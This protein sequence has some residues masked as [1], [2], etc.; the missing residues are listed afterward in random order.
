MSRSGFPRLAVRPIALLLL[1]VVV[2]TVSAA[3]RAEPQVLA[4]IKPLG[5]IA[6]EVVGQ[7]GEVGTLLHGSASPHDYAMRVSDIRRLRAADVVLWVGP[8]M[9][10]FLARP[11]ANLPPERILEAQELQGIHWPIGGDAGI[12]HGDHFHERDPH[13]WLDPRNGA[14]IARALAARL[15]EL[16]PSGADRY[17]ANA[18]RLAERLY[19]LDKDLQQR[20]QPV[21]GRGFAVYHEGYT[22]FIKRYELTQLGYV[23]FGPEQRPGARHLYQLRQRLA[24]AHC[25][26]LEPYYDTQTAAELAR[27]LGLPVGELDPLGVASSSYPGL[28][29]S[30]A[31]AFLDCLAPQT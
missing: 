12:Q 26:F 25:L 10:T 27:E 30:M 23:T 4:S 22:H 9:E 31:H 20:L 15:M 14:I 18:E 6:Q 16:D 3:V 1:F 21:T 7:G 11:L 24:D 17:Q 29:E 19:Q 8:E 5:L 2:S 28:I 13:I